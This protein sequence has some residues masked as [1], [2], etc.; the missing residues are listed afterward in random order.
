MQS[1]AIQMIS[2]CCLCTAERAHHTL[3]KI[4]LYSLQVASVAMQAMMHAIDRSCAIKAD[5]VALDEREGG[6]RATLNLGH[7]FGHAIEAAQG[8]GELFSIFFPPSTCVVLPEPGC[9]DNALTSTIA[10]WTICLFW[11]FETACQEIR[12]GY[13]ISCH[14]AE[15]DMSPGALADGAC[16]H[17]SDKL[18]IALHVRRRG[19]H[20]SCHTTEPVMTPSGP[21]PQM[22]PNHEDAP[23]SSPDVR[24]KQ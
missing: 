6:V 9:Q 16:Q 12:G 10:G 22:H 15:P 8:Y 1:C 2:N 14:A 18:G 13:H 7:T 24:T 17:S 21:S 3:L 23:R 5:I 4:M 11:A 20:I 19:L